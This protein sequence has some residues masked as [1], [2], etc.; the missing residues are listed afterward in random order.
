MSANY[1]LLLAEPAGNPQM[2]SHSAQVYTTNV[3][4]ALRC[5]CIFNLIPQ[6][7][8]ITFRVAL[9]YVVHFLA[10]VSPRQVLIELDGP[11]TAPIPHLYPQSPFIYAT[12]YIQHTFIHASCIHHTFSSL[13][14][15]FKLPIP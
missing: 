11:V 4:S 13:H 6:A 1:I 2:Q 10:A 3:M 7:G 8:W 5:Y 14:H 9:Q 15:T 12:L